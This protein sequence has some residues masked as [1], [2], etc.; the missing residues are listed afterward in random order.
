MSR[1]TWWGVAAAAALAAAG[2]GWL[3][4]PSE[5]AQDE[6]VVARTALRADPR[7]PG[8]ADARTH[9]G[10]P[11]GGPKG[12]ARPRR[13]PPPPSAER[14]EER[15]L[16]REDKLV[17]LNERL[18]R[19]AASAGWDSELTEEVRVILLDTTDHISA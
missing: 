17:D 13:E 19:Y 2:I 5:P 16:V 11:V 12:K 9:R 3:T 7:R 1:S 4:W 18:D 10:A 14:A 8:R 6:Q 15:E